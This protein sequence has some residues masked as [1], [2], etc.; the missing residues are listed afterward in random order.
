M[1][2]WSATPLEKDADFGQ[3]HA[4]E[5]SHGPTPASPRKVLSRRQKIVIAAVA[6]LLVVGAGLG[7]GLGISLSK[8]N[9]SGA[10]SSRDL[11]VSQVFARCAAAS[12]CAVD[13]D[14]MS[15]LKVR[16]SSPSSISR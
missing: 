14:G 10:G 16:A 11:T 12:A 5:L 3:P 6:G 15:T 8:K 7:A 1:T 4:V 13:T 9:K 2:T